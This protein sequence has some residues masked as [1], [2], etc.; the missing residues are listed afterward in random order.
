LEAVRTGPWRTQ[1]CAPRDEADPFL[2]D[3]FCSE[4]CFA[5]YATFRYWLARDNATRIIQRISKTFVLQTHL[6]DGI[7]SA[8]LCCT[9]S[10]TMTAAQI[11]LEEKGIEEQE[12]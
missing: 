10:T 12:G 3:D 5:I 6:F 1:P 9:S 2:R 7:P 8:S 4:L 11:Q